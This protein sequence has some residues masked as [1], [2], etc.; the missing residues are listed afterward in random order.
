M[1][2]GHDHCFD[3]RIRQFRLFLASPG[4]VEEERKHVRSAIEQLRGER[5]FRDRI[6]L[7][8]IAWDQ[9]G[10]AVPMEA[11]LTPQKAIMQGI[12][13]PSDCDLVVVIFCSRI[14]TPLPSEYV[15]PDDSRFLSGTEWEYHDAIMAFQENQTR[16]LVWLYRCEQPPKIS[17][18]DPDFEEKREQWD[19][20]QMFFSSFV[21]QDGSMSGG[22]NHYSTPGEFRK[23]FENHLRD[24]LTKE[25]EKLKYTG[26]P[27]RQS[28]GHSRLKINTGAPKTRPLTQ[29]QRNYKYFISHTHHNAN[30][31][32][33]ARFLHEQLTL[34]GHSVFIDIGMK[35]GMGWFEEIQ[36]QIEWCDYL[37]LLI[38]ETSMRSEMLVRE[39]RMARNNLRKT[40]KPHILPIRLNYEGPFEY[41]LNLYIGR[42]DHIS[43]QNRQDSQYVIDNIIQLPK[44]VKRCDKLSYTESRSEEYQ[45][46]FVAERDSKHILRPEDKKI[47]VAAHKIGETLVIKGPSQIGKTTLLQRYIQECEKARKKVCF[48]D[49]ARFGNE[50]L[51]S[52]SI[53]LSNLAW[54]IKEELDINN[55]EFPEIKNQNM[56]VSYFRKHILDVTI[57]HLTIAFDEVDRIMERSYSSEFFSM[58][59][60]FHES[61]SH[62]RWRET[63]LVLV[64]STEP[65]L[66]INESKRSPFN[67][68]LNVVL[69]PFSFE[70]CS[71]L[72]KNYENPLEKVEL[73]ELHILLQGHPF[74]TRLAYDHLNDTSPCSFD[75][76]IEQADDER[77][78]FGDQLRAKIVDIQKMPNLLEGMKKVLIPETEPDQDIA[79]RL[80]GAGLV[81]F[82]NDG[83]AVPANL[84]YY[85]Y[86]KKVLSV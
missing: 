30:N 69:N 36:R 2:E 84:L 66:F 80:H 71:A 57:G 72:N 45:P 82:K 46:E 6:K 47:L 8:C 48:I 83:K 58:L 3:Q 70:E 22:I 17:F 9:P 27:V 14:G 35:T 31:E 20:L 85:R 52:Y 68:G 18:D 15:K 28:D 7:E 24:L 54:S 40:G 65:H 50:E 74:L 51:S 86:F 75:E 13:K 23:K 25:L 5:A 42:L 32:N 43:W 62:T 34:L 77:G 79:D 41:E 11:A 61:R 26:K 33:L 78:I 21:N 73:E 59:K 29:V 4:D 56:M 53:F 44:E 63:D 37:V 49:F 39:V 64:I 81:S 55:S 1:T 10:I 12:P 60:I 67:V 16:P 76:L 38:S 19:S